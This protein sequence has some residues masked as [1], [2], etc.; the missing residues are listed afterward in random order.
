VNI[1]CDH[2]IEHGGNVE[3]HVVARGRSVAESKCGDKGG[4]T[5][6]H[7]TSTGNAVVPDIEKEVGRGR[8]K[9]GKQIWGYRWA[10]DEN[11]NISCDY[12]S[13][14]DGA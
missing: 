1:S 4:R 11:S 14:L 9:G 12:D 5:R 7:V 13:V 6:I 3:K 10:A 8:F 2:H